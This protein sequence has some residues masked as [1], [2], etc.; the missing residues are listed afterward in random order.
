MG[1]V[2]G[3]VE[4][5]DRVWVCGGLGVDRGGSGCGLGMDRA[6]IGSGDGIGAACTSSRETALTAHLDS[7]FLVGSYVIHK[8]IHQPQLVT[9]T[10]QDVQTRRVERNGVHLFGEHLERKIGRRREKKGPQTKKRGEL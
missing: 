9:E 1:E 3:E 4:G 8:E 5:V 6:W 10:S 7:E 2:E